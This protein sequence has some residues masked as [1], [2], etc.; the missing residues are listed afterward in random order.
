MRGFVVSLVFGLAVAAGSTQ[1]HSQSSDTSSCDFVDQVTLFRDG[2]GPGATPLSLCGRYPNQGGST[3]I[4]SYLGLRY[5][6]ADRW[7]AP[8]FA[9]P[10]FALPDVGLTRAGDTPPTVDAR[11]FA[12][13]CPQVHAGQLQR[14]RGRNDD[15]DDTEKVGIGD[16]DCLFL[17]IYASGDATKAPV[18]VFIHGGAFIEGSGGDGA[19]SVEIDKEGKV[20]TRF[21]PDRALYSGVGLIQAAEAQQKEKALPDGAKGLIL[22]TLNYRLGAL[23]FLYHNADDAGAGRKSYGNYGILDQKKALEWVQAN[24]A[25]FG[26]DPGNVTVFGESAGA[27][28]VGL[29]IFNTASGGSLFHR[30]IMESN[31]F[32]VPYRQHDYQQPN[33][34]IVAAE[35][36][37]ESCRFVRTAYDKAVGGGYA[38]KTCD[39]GAAAKSD[40]DAFP[41]ATGFEKLTEKNALD[42]YVVPAAV[43]AETQNAILPTLDDIKDAPG[44]QRWFA[45][46]PWTPFVGDEK[47][48]LFPGQPLEQGF[49][50]GSAGQ[51]NPIPVLLGTNRDEADLFVGMIGAPLAF[52]LGYGD[53]INA[54]L[55]NT[56]PDGLSA[57]EAVAAVHRQLATPKDDRDIQPYCGLP[58]KLPKD[59]TPADPA[60]F[61]C[62]AY[63]KETSGFVAADDTLLPFTESLYTGTTA[64]GR[65]GTDLVFRCGNIEVARTAIA[66]RTAQDT[67]VPVGMYLFSGAPATDSPVFPGDLCNNGDRKTYQSVCHGYELP[68]VFSTFGHFG[69]D[70]SDDAAWTLTS[71]TGDWAAFASTGTLPGEVSSDG[72]RLKFYPSGDDR[73][74]VLAPFAPSFP[75]TIDGMASAASCDT[76][77]RPDA[78]YPKWRVP[79]E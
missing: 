44:G 61:V 9:L 46:L 79:G 6:R 8:D 11:N 18:M 26:G 25:E 43:I 13:V 38:E 76:V 57:N 65:V 17:N 54:L 35:V 56:R 12:T 49:Y 20:A 48:V 50:S 68:A 62:P 58:V 40:G 24:I 22:V 51:A 36:N 23:G 70:G 15:G 33:D 32:G 21:D 37:A 73:Q 52:D 47:G 7:Q 78:V 29:H 41:Y 30:A 16:D 64:F 39:Y 4:K 69:P 71:T 34:G 75:G 74:A 72:I 3:A 27:M 1:A 53:A 28:S 42:G 55:T 59:L 63:S 31:P 67:P 66:Q 14:G 10:D 5:A 2:S 77:W 60:D 19:L 45:L